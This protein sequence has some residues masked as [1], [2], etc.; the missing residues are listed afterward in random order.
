VAAPDSS[1]WQ[2]GVHREDLRAAAAGE[3]HDVRQKGSKV[4]SNTKPLLIVSAVCE[5]GAGLLLLIAP[6]PTARVLLGA[7]LMSPESMVVG[8][9]GGA[10][11]LSIG[12]SCWLERNRD[13]EASALGLVTGLLVYNVAAVVL[14]AYAALVCKMN[15]IGIWPTVGLHS[16]LFIWCARRLRIERLQPTASAL[17][18]Q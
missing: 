11:L 9:V 14:F 7:G 16:A 18:S 6:S 12:L 2:R 3:L 15:G 1:R 4:L 13:P 8:R 17:S 10:A 5:I